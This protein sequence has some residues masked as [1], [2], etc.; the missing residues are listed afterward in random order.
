MREVCR[1]LITSTDTT[2]CKNRILG[3]DVHALAILCLSDNTRTMSV[4][5]N[6]ICHGRIFINRYIRKLFHLC[7][8]FARNLL[9]CDI[10]VKKDSWS[11]MCPFSCIK[12]FITVMSK[13]NTIADQVMNNLLRTANHNIN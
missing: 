10:L 4:L 7:K 11:G 13:I 3:M 5:Y 9:S 12:K 2:A 8:K 1:V 6:N